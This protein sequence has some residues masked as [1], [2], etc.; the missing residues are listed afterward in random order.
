MSVFKS[1]KVKD[2]MVPI[3]CVCVYLHINHQ[4]SLATLG[5]ITHRAAAAATLPPLPMERLVHN[6]VCLGKLYKSSHLHMINCCGR[7]VCHVHTVVGYWSWTAEK[8][9]GY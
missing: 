2:C 7:S 4:L 9:K 1:N 5:R 8:L 3:A 6:P